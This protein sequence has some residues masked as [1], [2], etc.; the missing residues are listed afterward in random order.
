MPRPEPSQRT[1]F[2]N[3][4]AP[5]AASGAKDRWRRARDPRRQAILRPSRS[6]G[7]RP[8][9]LKL[10]LLPAEKPSRQTW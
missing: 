9:S 7:R 6:T 3:Q 1:R 2:R 10:A 5:L 8:Q 4:I